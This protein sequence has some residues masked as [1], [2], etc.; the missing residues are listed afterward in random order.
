MENG[1]SLMMGTI[2]ILCKADLVGFHYFP[3]LSS[4]LT[5]SYN[6]KAQTSF[7]LSFLFL[8][9]HTCCFPLPPPLLLLISIR[10]ASL[11][12]SCLSILP[13]RLR[14]GNSRLWGWGVDGLSKHTPSPPPPPPPHST[15]AAPSLRV[16]RR[17]YSPR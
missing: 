5:L 9:L 12:H 10:L 6:L 13:S 11:S 8:S 17:A 4:E 1:P 15:P 3:M 14:C 7:C 2:L 16:L